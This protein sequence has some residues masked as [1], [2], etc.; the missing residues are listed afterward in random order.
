VHGV[1]PDFQARIRHEAFGFVP[2]AGP[3]LSTEKLMK[4]GHFSD[5]GEKRRPA[6]ISHG[7]LIPRG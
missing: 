7:F 1:P 2:Y 6:R 3:G 5:E 4:S